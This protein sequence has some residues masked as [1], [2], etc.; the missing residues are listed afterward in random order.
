MN[1]Q[2]EEIKKLIEEG[3]IGIDASTKLSTIPDQ[4]KRV[5]LAKT[6]AGLSAEQTRQTI[7]YFRKH[8]N[9]SL[10]DCREAA[11]NSKPTKKQV[12][13]VT[14]RLKSEDY[15]AFIAASK[16]AGLH[17]AEAGKQAIS[18]WMKNSAKTACS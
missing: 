13:S 17:P 7:A 1:E 15:E 12:K 8:S 10:N 5:E 14:I 18:E 4:R 16:K 3:K 2:P 11:I 6:V 9:V